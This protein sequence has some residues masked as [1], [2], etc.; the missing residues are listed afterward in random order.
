M[1]NK[2]MICNY[3]AQAASM[4]G[5][6]NRL[7][8]ITS[9]GEITGVLASGH[10]DHPAADYHAKMV[11]NACKS[12]AIGGEL[13]L[14]DAIITTNGVSTKVGAMVVFVDSIIAVFLGE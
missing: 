8:L 9:A 2:T 4:P 12:Q 3:L 11:K 13:V 5:Q 14:R 7:H 6:T 1:D 10:D